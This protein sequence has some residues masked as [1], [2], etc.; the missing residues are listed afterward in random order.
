MKPF[1]LSVLV[2]LVIALIFLLMTF[3]IFYEFSST[4]RSAETSLATTGNY[5]GGVATLATA[6]I[7]AYLYSDW[8][9]PHNS[10]IEA[11]HNKQILDSI[12]SIEPTEEKFHRLITDYIDGK[13]QLVGTIDLYL[14]DDEINTFYTNVNNL[15]SLLDELYYMTNDCA[16]MNIKEHYYNYAK[17]YSAILYGLREY[18]F[19]NDLDFKEFL[20]E[21]AKC[22][23]KDKDNKVHI[24]S[25]RYKNIFQGIK[26]TR[27]KK[28]ISEIIKK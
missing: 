8:R 10:N 6:I 24:E 23:F 25:I 1:V 16:V 21:F 14:T 5:F 22:D 13:M 3:W 26:N 11:Q 15:L 7:A 9:D 18:S 4:S 20:K 28:Y 17:H 27:L 12:R 19:N 2:S